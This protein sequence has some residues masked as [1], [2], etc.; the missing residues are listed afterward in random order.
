[1]PGLAELRTGAQRMRATY[2]PVPE[3]ATIR[4]GS[5]GPKLIAALHQW[6]AAQVDEHGM[7]ATMGH[8]M[9]SS[10]MPSKTGAVK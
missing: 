9:S 1:M 7:H 5:R 4:Y 6:F 8:S 3:G 2:A 10:A